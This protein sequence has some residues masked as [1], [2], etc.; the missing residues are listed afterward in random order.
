MQITA[1]IIT[2]AGC[3]Q[4]CALEMARWVKAVPHV[5]N[6]IIELE[7]SIE[8]ACVLGYRLQTAR[9]VLVKLLKIE[10]IEMLMSLSFPESLVNQLI[11]PDHTFKAEV[12]VLRLGGPAGGPAAKLTAQ[13]FVEEVGGWFHTASKRKVALNRPDH[14]VYGVATAQG[15]WV[16]IDVMGRSLSRREY[17]VMLS[18]RSLKATIA[19]SAV[20]LSGASEKGT[21]LDPFAD[22][23]SIVVEAA[24]LRSGMSPWQHSKG[25]SFQK[26]PVLAGWDAWA[27][28]CKPIQ[29]PIIAYTDSLQELKAIR[30]N[31]KI[32]GVEKEIHAT[33]VSLDWVD[34]K[35][36]TRSVRAIVTSPLQSGKSIDAKRVVKVLDRFFEQALFVL[37]KDGVIVCV[38][39]KPEEL[40]GPAQ[41]AGFSV[42]SQQQVLM[43]L[44]RM[45]IVQFLKK[46]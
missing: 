24:L 43:G 1:L 9:R 23:G 3:E 7:C 8:D 27:K 33:K 21:L 38:T 30:T 15:I 18:R 26:F 42:F 44:R 25:F 13:E 28:P 6:Q 46:K 40:L 19:A 10:R 4:A 32:A 37:G 29:Q 5:G 2:D 45:T 22:D 14:V 34:I 16:G 35:T 20:M 12:D 39:E 11:G 17:R 41:R 36:D 31:A